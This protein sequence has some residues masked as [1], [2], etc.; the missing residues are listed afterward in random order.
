LIDWNV[1]YVD[2]ARIYQPV[3]EAGLPSAPAEARGLDRMFRRFGLGRHKGRSKVLDVSCGIG[4]HS[5]NLVKLGYEVVGFDFS[6]HFLRTARRLAKQ[7]DIGRDSLQ[8]VEGDASRLREILESRGE[9]G[10]DA[11]ISMD[12]SIVRQT[13]GEERKLLHSMYEVARP[14]SVLVVETANR[15]FFVKHQSP[16]PLVQTFDGGKLQRHIQ[17]T[18]DT[19][20][21]HIKGA[22]AFYRRRQNGDLKHL[23][24]FNWDSN[25]HSE[26]DLREL[27]K[28]SGWVHLK[29]YGNV[30]KLD[31]LDSDSFHIVM[32][33]R[34]AG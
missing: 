13:L 10:F 16:L 9:T 34:R 30:Q 27:L 6:P 32:V 7:E 20:K 24:T 23:L 12:T 8:F 29:S 25:I 5:I 14:G 18:Y 21:R 28:G 15:D 19:R 31:K 17:A 11:V 4:R 1:I 3:L 33:A 2:N 26:A 22:W